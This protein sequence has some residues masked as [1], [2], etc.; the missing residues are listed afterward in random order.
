MHMQCFACAHELSWLHRERTT[1]RLQFWFT[2]APTHTSSANGPFHQLQP[3]H[4][5]GNI[6]SRQTCTAA[7]MRHG[8]APLPDTNASLL[9]C[10]PMRCH[11]SLLSH[12]ARPFRTQLLATPLSDLQST[13]PSTVQRRK[14]GT[15]TAA[16]HVA[17]HNFIWRTRSH[18][19]QQPAAAL[20]VACCGVL[21]QPA[22]P[23][24]HAAPAPRCYAASLNADLCGSLCAWLGV[25]IG[26][27][28]GAR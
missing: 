14:L 10:S 19:S 12:T 5:I 26:V 23:P 17:V 22:V 27:S 20:A 25:R 11:P 13:Q 15:A 7:P 8:H 3:A 16:S 1:T 18:R 24:L 21:E 4:S 2:T 9:N 6:C 28:A